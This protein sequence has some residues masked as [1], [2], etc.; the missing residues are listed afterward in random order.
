MLGVVTFSAFT[1]TTRNSTL[2]ADAVAASDV[3]LL[4]QSWEFLWWAERFTSKPDN[5][6]NRVRLFILL[7]VFSAAN[8]IFAVNVQVIK[9]L[10]KKWSSYCRCCNSY[11]WFSF[12]QGV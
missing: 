10:S 5:P 9:H 3:N 4:S 6:R 7:S 1:V 11:W 2:F 12:T 8:L